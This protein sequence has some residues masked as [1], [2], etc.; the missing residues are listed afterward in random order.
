MAT[1]LVE[2]ASS[3]KVPPLVSKTR[4]LVISEVGMVT[5]KEPS[6][7]V[8][9]DLVTSTPADFTITTAPDAG[10]AR[11]EPDTEVVEEDVDE[12]PEPPPPQPKI[13]NARQ[14]IIMSLMV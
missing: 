3:G 2:V 13:T 8:T 6:A 11:T 1:P 12:L 14:S 9:P 7:A 5:V 4:S 10:P